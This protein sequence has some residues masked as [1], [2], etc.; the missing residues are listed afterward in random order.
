[1]GLLLQAQLV[2]IT[3]VNVGSVVTTGF[4]EIGLG[5]YLWT[6]DQFPDNFGG[7]VIFSQ[8]SGPLLAFTSI[9]PIQI[10]PNGLDQISVENGINLRQAMSVI[11]SV[12]AGVMNGNGTNN[13]IINAIQNPGINRVTAQ[14]D[15]SGNRSVVTLNLP[16]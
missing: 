1:V 5:N 10:S 8:I 11:S 9:N 12:L 15:Q 7:G 13:I 16:A 4:V 3:G 6:Y 14:I 2:D